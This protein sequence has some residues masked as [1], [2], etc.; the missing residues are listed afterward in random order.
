MNREDKAIFASIL[1]SQTALTKASEEKEKQQ[2]EAIGKIKTLIKSKEDMITNWDAIEEFDHLLYQACALDYKGKLPKILDDLRFWLLI[3]PESRIIDDLWMRL[4]HE[5]GESYDRNSKRLNNV[6]INADKVNIQLLD[7]SARIK[8]DGE[9]LQE[10]ER[11]GNEYYDEEN[12]D[13]E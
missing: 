9:R 6:M 12:G 1:H 10:L 13:D 7:K 11:L 5:I 2:L 3:A 4:K 8:A